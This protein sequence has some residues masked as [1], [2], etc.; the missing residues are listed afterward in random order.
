MFLSKMPNVFGF[1]SIRPAVSSVAIFSKSSMSTH[2]VSSLLTTVTSKPAILALAG[3][4]PWAES[5]TITSLLSSPCSLWYAF[6]MRHPRNSPWAP[7]AGMKE[8]LCIPVISQ[9]IFSSL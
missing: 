4:V 1:V 9:S 5:G 3:F 7:A 6:I 2:P 8:N